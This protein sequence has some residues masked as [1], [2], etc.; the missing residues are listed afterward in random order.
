MQ[1]NTEVCKKLY[2]RVLELVNADKETTVIDAYSGAGL[3][4]ACLAKKAKKAIGVE[5]IKEAVE[6]ADSLKKLN[7]LEDKMENVCG[8]CEEILPPLIKKLRANGEKITIVLD[9][10]RKGCDKK[11]LDVI[12]DADIDRVV[13]IS[14]NPSTLSRDLGIL[15][16]TLIETPEGLKKTNLPPTNYTVE[17]ATPF[18]MFPH[19]K[20]VETLVCLTRKI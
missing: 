14:C 1:V 8:A 3:M 18:D 4:T 6:C 20:H 16:G 7:G 15:T 10:P 2:G 11:V 12:K 9:P 5:I 13:Y 19:T 17:V